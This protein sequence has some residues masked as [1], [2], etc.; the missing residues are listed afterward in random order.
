MLPLGGGDGRTDE[1][2]GAGR[3]RNLTWTDAQERAE[4]PKLGPPLTRDEVGCRIAVAIQV[5]H[6]QKE[7]QCFPLGGGTKVMVDLLH[8]FRVGGARW[9]ASAEVRASVRR[10]M[11]PFAP[12]GPAGPTEVREEGEEPAA[13]G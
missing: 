11:R 4:L 10:R 5:R 9:G 6:R 13:G 7:E 8:D 3:E 2:E 1:G 12:C